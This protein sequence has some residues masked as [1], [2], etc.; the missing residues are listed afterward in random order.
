MANTGELGSYERVPFLVSFRDASP[1]RDTY[2]GTGEHVTLEAHL[3]R[4]P[5]PSDTVIVAMHPIGGGSYL[6]M[7]I[8]LARAGHHVVF[9]NSRYRGVDAALV[10][11]KV[12][13]DLGACVDH[14]TERLG[15]AKVVLAGWSG[16]G[17][18]SMYYQQQAE[19]PS[20]TATPAGDP[21]DL[22]ALGL[23]PADAV[24]M[25]AAHVS[26]HG[27][28]TEWL[29][30]SILDEHDPSVRDVELDLYDP[31]NPNQPPYTAE[32]LDRYRAA[33]IARN[34]RITAW[35][36][37]KLA[38]LKA[39]G[40][41]HDEFAFVVHGTM[42]DPRWLDPTVDPNDR[43][44]GWCYQGDPRVVNMSPTGLA[45]FTTLR[46][47]LSQWSYDEARGDALTAARDVTVP[48]LV[49]GNSADDACTPSHTQRIFDAVPHTDKE[50]HIIA[51][52][53]HYY[54][55]PDQKPKLAE[56]VA[57]ITGWL[58]RHDLSTGP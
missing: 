2:G 9:C 48:V 22:T 58:D 46:S 31:A 35:V 53:T 38:G 20:V 6:P 24:L 56:A 41:E 42:A 23:R 17:A 36:K 49:I 47:W 29:D 25:L 3:L 30:A 52:A 15:Y 45:R 12:V 16:G 19:R 50:L 26:R 43:R 32:F 40:H 28:L 51:G 21:P 57:T 34:R 11:E 5:Q 10:M 8:A 14:V 1:V 33:Q 13:E 55:G 54:A 44:P 4:P 7:T 18:L 39:A 27:T 37:A